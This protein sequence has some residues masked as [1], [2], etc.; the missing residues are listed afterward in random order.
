[1]L[2]SPLISGQSGH[3]DMV[4]ADRALVS[5]NIRISLACFL[6]I[7]CLENLDPSVQIVYGCI[8]V[9][10]D[11]KHMALSKRLELVIVGKRI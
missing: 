8:K 6:L 4:S 5:M 11:V 10:H 3:L 9:K 7:I 2:I 1:M